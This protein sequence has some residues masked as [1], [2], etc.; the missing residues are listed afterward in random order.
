MNLSDNNELPL[1]FDPFAGPAIA[2]TAASSEAQREIWTAT[3]VGADASLAYNESITLILRGTVDM[4]ALRAAFA[5]VVMRH[6]ALRTTLSADGLTLCIS[7]DASPPPEEEDLSQ[8]DDA[9]RSAALQRLLAHELSTP[10]DLERGPLYR[11][12]FLRVHAQEARV[13]FTAHHIV[14]DG[15]STAVIV[16]D[17]ARLYNACRAGR[18]AELPAAPTLRSY[19][20]QLEAQARADDER[21]WLERFAAELPVLDLPGDR[22]RPPL[23]S[24][25]SARC[26]T[27]LDPQLMAAVRAAAAQQRASLFILLLAAFKALLLRL[28]GQEDLVVGVPSAGQS[29]PGFEQLVGHCV[30]MLPL[31]TRVTRELRFSELLAAVRGSVLDGFEH[32][33]YTFGSLLSKLPIPRDVSRSPLV[34]VVFNLDRGLSSE[35]MGFEGLAAECHTNARQS[36][37][38]ELFLNIVELPT[39]LV[40]ECQY[41]TDLFG[42]DTIA[43]WLAAYE[44]ILRAVVADPQLTVGQLPVV[45]E[46]ELE[47]Y[48][49]WNAATYRAHGSE[50]LA[51]E[52]VEETAAR[53]PDAIACVFEGAEISYAALNARANQLAR[54]LRSTGVGR[55]AL[56]GVCM[57]RSIELLV[58]VLGVLKA[59]ATYVPLDPGYPLERLTYMASDAHMA[60]LGHQRSTHLELP[61]PAAATVYP[62]ETAAES[63]D[64]LTSEASASSPAYVIYTSGSTGKPKGVVVG[65][66]SLANL[67]HSV[68][69]V[70]G[71]QASDVVL[72]VTTLAFD[73]AI[74]ELILP[75]CVGAKIVLVSR[76]VA[77]DGASL[78]DVVQQHGVT[79]IDATPA[80]YRLLLSAGFAGDSKITAICTGE[81][82]PRDLALELVDKVAALWNGYG[83]T[84][85]T[86]WSSFSRIQKPIE[87]ISIGRP[88]DNTHIH[89]LDS[90]RQ[91]TPLGVPGEI[92]IAGQGLALGYLNRP[93]L[94]AERFVQVAGQRMYRTGDLGRYL[95]SGELE[96]LGRTDTQIKLR[97]YRIELGEI[98]N[99][100]GQHALVQQA[101]VIV[102]EDRPGHPHLVAYLTSPPTAAAAASAALRTHLQQSLPDYM[103]PAAYVWL[104]QMPLTPSG[105]VDRRALPAPTHELLGA[106][107]AF[108]PPSTP[109]QKL[110][111]ALWQTALSVPRVSIHDD[112]FAIGGHSLLASQILARLRQDH[113]IK[114]SFRKLFEAP[115]IAQLAEVVDALTDAGDTGVYSRPLERRHDLGPAPLSVAQ[116]RLWLLEQMDPSQELVHNL[117]AAWRLTGPVELASLQRALD[118]IVRRHETLRTTFTWRDGR[119]VQ[120]VA[121]AGTLPIALIDLRESAEP[122]RELRAQIDR[123]TRE[124]FDLEHGPL[125]RSYLFQLAP[126]EHVYFSVCHNIIWDGWSFDVFLRELTT[127]YSASRSGTAPALTDLPVSYSDYVRWHNQFLEGPE[128]AQQI[129]WWRER[130]SG[131]L[132]ELT[133]PSDRPR[134]AQ[135]EHLGGNASIALTRA[136]AEALTALGRESGATLFMVLFAAFNVLLHRYSEQTTLL[137]GTPVRARNRHEA[138]PLIGPFVNALVLRTDLSPELRF[139]ELLARVRDETL[140]AFSHEDMPLERLGARPPMVRAFFSFQDAR[141][142]P[143][144]LGEAQISQIHV[145]P[146]AAANDLM[147][148]TMETA[149]ELHAVM[150]YSA[151]L[152]DAATI[153]R[154]LGGYRGLL[155]ALA[156]TPDARIG[157]LPVAAD[158]D[159]E[160]LD[161]WGNPVGEPAPALAS[162]VQRWAAQAGERIAVSDGASTLSYAELW[163]R[164]RAL[165][166]AIRARAPQGARLAVLSD[167]SLARSIALVAAD[168]SGASVWLVDPEHPEA[169]SRAL[170]AAV[171]PDGLIDARSDRS[172]SPPIAAAVHIELAALGDPVAPP[173]P[174]RAGVIFWVARV[175]IEVFPV[176]G[177]ALATGAAALARALDV[178]PG[179]TVLS[180][181]AVSAELAAYELALPLMAGAT[182]VQPR[183]NARIDRLAGYSH[184]DIVLGAASA[185][186]AATA[187]EHAMCGAYVLTS[188]ASAAL[189]ALLSKHGKP[190]YR[191]AGFAEAELAPFAQ[192]IA[193]AHEAARL[194]RALYPTRAAVLDER[195]APAPIGVPGTLM[196]AGRRTE[197][198]ARFMHDGTVD[199]VPDTTQHVDIAGVRIAL[200]EI[201]AQLE[202]HASIARARVVASHTHTGAPRLVGYV[203]LHPSAPFSETEVRHYLQRTLPEYALPHAY[204]EVDRPEGLRD[205]TKLASPTGEDSYEAPRTPTE[206][207]LAEHWARAL[208][209]ERISVHDNFFALGGHSLL[210]FEVIAALEKRSGRRLHPR[211][212]LLGTLAQVA[213]ELDA[214]ASSA[215]AQQAPAPQ[216]GILQ[217]LKQ[218]VR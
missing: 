140:D 143:P 191:V 173:Q 126:A 83:P 61:L 179:Q 69:K 87:R 92:Y 64:N 141:S 107:A 121:S 114:L 103:L 71:M 22:P 60:A 29:Q 112:F 110:L 181:S 47:Q 63:T 104:A 67:L 119:V 18:Q 108:V 96:C 149:R 195:G 135:S 131:E 207:L 176:S 23:K 156:V 130:L 165:A 17:W 70:P 8:L 168:L 192:A 118:E 102:R 164:A 218:L 166:E 14:V 44:R 106:R 184:F 150:N 139:S 132:P 26:D 111:A 94:S 82:L 66:R 15:W 76:E 129:A 157:A 153:Q 205:I 199:L 40:L 128:V 122:E 158:G 113:G 74:S 81:A 37:N 2:A 206:Q 51:H 24:Y 4:T 183:R 200:P 35:A 182:L 178:L 174:E 75:L 163:L 65:Q 137:V 28:S 30:N 72:A 56:V 68:A 11:V 57:E 58:A 160:L 93:E 34:S 1:D 134:P 10:F 196:L 124:R 98:E 6:E 101:A 5:D 3:L 162:T 155:R 12:H 62:D 161:S 20:C 100:L 211:I 120:D 109:T 99:A 125:F 50:R 172:T 25:R 32:R 48:A 203:V 21:Y 90:E 38:F 169:R 133:L 138:E 43:R 77:A 204:I 45:S 175:E 86:V 49:R 88:V 9:G 159:A 80:T 171:Q 188:E 170:C 209:L 142:R 193:G 127:L 194:G 105:K 97:G 79:W 197:H 198:R 7:L 78:L 190:L 59:G 185:F 147:L 33:D 95:A 31:R 116:E 54:R 41:N 55:D 167:T 136:D 16:Q 187:R 154:M 27:T 85:T 216:R 19:H 151:E 89:I 52:L 213:L 117:P 36:E 145:E 46:H 148:W 73:I 212:M 214:S 42:A 13:V 215:P 217:R 177:G 180:L 210:C 84:E 144:A 123:Y 208:Q 39:G 115:T 186:A 202:T 201:Q 53:T 146:R 152:F 189:V 91:P